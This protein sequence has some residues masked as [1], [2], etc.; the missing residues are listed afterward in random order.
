MTPLEPQIWN[1]IMVSHANRTLSA[2]LEKTANGSLVLLF[3]DGYELQAKPGVWGGMSSQARHV[4][5]YTKR[6]ILRQQVRTGFYSAF[7]ALVNSLKKVG[8]DVRVND[9]AAAEARPQYPIGLAGYPSI[10]EKIKLPNP[11]IFGP[12]DF[13]TPP[14]S[15]TVAADPRFRTLIQPSDWFSWRRFWL[16]AS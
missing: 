1:Y 14:A 3:Y 8:C 16:L 6:S 11:R 15:V 12:G 5:R 10:I 9:F 7:V 4:L 13:G 2:G